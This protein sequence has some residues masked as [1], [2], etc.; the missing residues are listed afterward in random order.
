MPDISLHKLYIL[1]ICEL[2]AAAAIGLLA[3]ASPEAS[4]KAAAFGYALTSP[5]AMPLETVMLPLITADLFGEHSYE[6]ML[7]IMVSINTAGYALSTPLT[8]LCYD[9]LGTY[10]P[11]LTALMILMIIVLILFLF[12]LRD[13]ARIRQHP[14]NR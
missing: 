4:G 12:V 6:K 2:S 1:L 7:G 14:E 3:A 8:N 13:A 11:A 10:V 9:K 5:M